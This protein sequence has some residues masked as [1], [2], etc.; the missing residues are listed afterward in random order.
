MS[1]VKLSEQLVQE[2]KQHAQ[3]AHRSTPKQIEFWARMGKLAD[4]NPDMTLGFVKDITTS[5]VEMKRGD[6]TEYEFG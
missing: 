5:L 2:A 6:V 4:E 3:A 1:T